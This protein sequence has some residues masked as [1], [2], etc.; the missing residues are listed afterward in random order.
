MGENLTTNN[1]NEFNEVIPI[2]EN[3]RENVFRAVNR[4]LIN[5]YWDMGKYESRSQYCWLADIN[6]NGI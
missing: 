3:S 6:D 5:M 4:E 1:T 2:I